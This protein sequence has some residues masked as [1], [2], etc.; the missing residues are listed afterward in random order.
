M[1]LKLPPLE[2]PA[3]DPF[4]FDALSRKESIQA[5]STFIGA[6]TPPFTLAIDSPWGTGKSTFIRMWKAHLELQNY[7]CLYFDAWSTDFAND[8]LVAFLG[9]LDELSRRI[10]PKSIA[11][12]QRAK[13]IAT[14]LAKRALPAVGKIATG[15]LLDVD[16]LAEKALSEIAS[17]A[18]KDLVDVYTAEK[19]L[20]LRF[21]ES[22][23]KTI[24]ELQ[25]KGKQPRLIIFLDEVDR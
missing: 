24:A 2:V 4:K 6:V 15:G 8:P 18:I 7:L 17:D 13:K 12:L 19:D 23:T 20:I 3:A 16:E 11:H 5:L 14:V 25:A 1:E 10:H 9:E 22:L 21:R